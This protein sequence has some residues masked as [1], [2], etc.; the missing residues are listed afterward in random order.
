MNNSDYDSIESEYLC[1]ISVMKLW[2]LEKCEQNRSI[3][4]KKEQTNTSL[5]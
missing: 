5:C 1:I 4:L 2:N 3:K